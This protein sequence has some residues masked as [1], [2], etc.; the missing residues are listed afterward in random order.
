MKKTVTREVDF[1]DRCGK[2]QDYL[3]AC[4]GC[5]MEVCWQCSEAVGVTYQHGVYFRGSGD[6]FYC[7]SCDIAL[8]ETN[9][10]PLH[11][12]YR[13]VRALRD[14]ATASHNDFKRRQELAEGNLALLIDKVGIH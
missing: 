7:R 6:G 11:V 4:L 5:R 2:E 14:E 12:A 13:A 3:V 9:A 1:C 8:S 10:D